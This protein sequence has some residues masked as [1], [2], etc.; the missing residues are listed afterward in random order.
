[1]YFLLPWA[2]DKILKACHINVGYILGSSMSF[3]AEKPGVVLELVSLS[4]FLGVGEIALKSPG[5]HTCHMVPW[6]LE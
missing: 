2:H 1:M 6:A 4:V 3:D 5:F